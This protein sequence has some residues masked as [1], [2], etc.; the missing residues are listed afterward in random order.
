MISKKNLLTKINAS[1][2]K[3]GTKEYFIMA[4]KN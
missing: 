3:T 4:L 1:K 2:N